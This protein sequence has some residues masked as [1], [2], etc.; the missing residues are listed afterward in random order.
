M[1]VLEGI[2]VEKQYKNYIYIHNKSEI[3]A[4]ESVGTEVPRIPQRA[5]QERWPRESLRMEEKKF[6]TYHAA[7]EQNY[8]FANFAAFLLPFECP[9]E[10]NFSLKMIEFDWACVHRGTLA[11]I[12][13]CSGGCTVDRVGD[14]FFVLMRP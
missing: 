14:K 9:I 6:Y 7:F 4:S 1:I 3:I 5:K 2:Q 8:Y 12:G 13:R 10:N 11:D